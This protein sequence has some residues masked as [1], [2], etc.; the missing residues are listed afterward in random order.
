MGRAKQNWRDRLIKSRK[1]EA[2]KE[3]EQTI[4]NEQIQPEIEQQEQ[5]T[6]ENQ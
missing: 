1:Y 4:E 3:M 2:L 5:A 6:R